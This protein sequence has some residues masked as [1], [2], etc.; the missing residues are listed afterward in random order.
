MLAAGATT[1]LSLLVGCSASSQQDR[2]QPTAATTVEAS[3]DP[4][5][6]FTDLY[7]DSFDS[8]AA[9]LSDAH[10][11]RYADP[12]QFESTSHLLEAVTGAVVATIIT[13][14]APSLTQPLKHAIHNDLGYSAAD[15]RVLGRNTARG[16]TY[17][18]IFHRQAKDWHKDLTLLTQGDYG[19]RQHATL[20][21]EEPR[22]P[23]RYLDAL[24]TPDDP[25]TTSATAYPA[26]M[27]LTW[28]EADADATQQALAQI[29]SA[30][31]HSVIGAPP[32]TGVVGYT[33][34]AAMELAYHQ[35]ISYKQT[36]NEEMRI[37]AAATETYHNSPA[38]YLE[39]P[40]QNGTVV[41]TPSDSYRGPESL[42]LS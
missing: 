26:L 3:N 33:P 7:T 40:L 16:H 35:T 27:A 31:D 36:F 25:I 4:F 2:P 10:R 24:W 18:A 38:P 17:T 9:V 6:T 22:G 29:R 28:A 39:V 30:N 23:A 15:I 20:A 12:S 19:Y 34:S 11:S 1:G 37:V 5:T 42:Y 41:P 21:P 32:A 13:S 8:D 14:D